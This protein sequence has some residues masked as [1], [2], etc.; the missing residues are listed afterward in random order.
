M[1]RIALYRTLEHSYMHLKVAFYLDSL[2][3]VN[4]VGYNY[5][6]TWQMLIIWEASNAEHIRGYR[7]EKEL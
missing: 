1:S 2:A 3:L 5:L 7:L 6:N 4:K